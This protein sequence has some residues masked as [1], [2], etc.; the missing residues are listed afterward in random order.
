MCPVSQIPSYFSSDHFLSLE[1]FLLN[2]VQP[3]LVVSVCLSFALIATADRPKILPLSLPLPRL[4][5]HFR[6]LLIPDQVGVMYLVAFSCCI[7][8][9]E[10]C[11]VEPLELFLFLPRSDRSVVCIM[12]LGQWW[13][14][15]VFCTSIIGRWSVEY[16]MYWMVL[17]PC[18]LSPA[19]LYTT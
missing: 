4:P 10:F 14:F 1:V 12:L 6:L 3:A 17:F 9:L 8:I 19:S 13:Y 15:L 16:G 5:C 11:Q 18:Y 2:F 7:W